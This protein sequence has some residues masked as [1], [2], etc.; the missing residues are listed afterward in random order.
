MIQ[1]FHFIEAFQSG[2]PGQILT[3]TSLACA[4]RC[5]IHKSFINRSAVDQN[6]EAFQVYEQYLR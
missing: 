1:A 3:P 6:L 2:N 5:T 4:H